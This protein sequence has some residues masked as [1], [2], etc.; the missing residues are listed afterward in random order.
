M[1]WTQFGIVATFLWSLQLA[2]YGVWLFRRCRSRTACAKPSGGRQASFAQKANLIAF[3]VFAAVATVEAQ[4]NTS[5]NE[6]PPRL[7][8]PRQLK[9]KTFFGDTG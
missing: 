4:K 1:N 6:P 8:S 7:A 5:T 3:A 2:V 9:R